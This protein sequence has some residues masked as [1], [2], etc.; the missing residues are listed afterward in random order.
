MYSDARLKTTLATEVAES[1]LERAAAGQRLDRDD[2]LNLYRLPAEQVRAA[3]HE[4]RLQRVDRPL[5]TYSIYGNIDYTNVCSVGCKFCCYFRA[6][7]ADD[8]F[9]LSHEQLGEQIA[10]MREEDVNNLLLMGGINPKLDLDWYIGMLQAAKQAHPEIWIDAFSPEEIIG[11]ERVSGLEAPEILAQ[12]KQ[13]GMD[14]LPGVSAEIL[15]DEVRHAV[16]PNRIATADW[17]RIVEA[18]FDAGLAVPCVSMVFGMGETT[19]HHVDHLLSLRDLQDRVLAKHGRGVQSFEVW[20]MRLQHSRISDSA[21]TSDPAD[22]A[23]D[24][25]H[26]LAAPGDGQPAKP[27]HRLAH[28][29]LRGRR[30]GP[31]LG[32]RRA[33]GDRDDQRDHRRHQARRPRHR[34]PRQ[35]GRTAQRHPQLHPRRRLHS[36]PSWSA[37]GD[38]RDRGRAAAV[39][40]R[41]R[42]SRVNLRDESPLAAPAS[43]ARGAAGERL[44]AADGLALYAEP[45]LIG[46]GMRARRRK[47][48]LTGEDVFTNVNCHINLTNVC[49]ASC[50]YCGFATKEGRPDAYLLSE[51][52]VAERARRAASAGVREFHLVGGLHPTLPLER[53]LG[54]FRL[55]HEEVPGANVRAF[56]AVEVDHYARRDGRSI[57]AVLEDLIEAGV[58]AITGG[59]AEIFAPAVRRPLTGHDVTWERWAAVHRAAHGMGMRTSA[60]MLY[61]HVESAEDRVDH[62][63]RL[64]ELQDDTG[65]FDVFVPLRFQP[66]GR[67]AHLTAPTATEVLR[68]FAV[69]RL[70]LDNFEHVKTFTPMNGLALSQLAIEFG[71][72]DIEGTISDYQITSDPDA[73]ELAGACAGTA[74]A[75]EPD[76]MPLAERYHEAFAA[77]ARECGWRPVARES[78]Y[79]ESA[80]ERLTA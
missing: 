44:S 52:Q 6:P 41:A 17:F 55:L 26:H 69:S 68:V 57:E 31:A 4:V 38:P 42:R 22:I 70:L 28:D 71:A 36:G 30:P 50:R 9:T 27:P 29:G 60:T 3:A 33:L 73:A 64:R 40:V 53:F 75:G 79:R 61:G 1:L 12:L 23:H 18:A 7:R 46:L 39:R 43:A 2:L 24:Y 54:V 78:G 10:C 32:C 13:A 48:E 15:V 14:A 19:E 16:A 63:L 11:M 21:P 51:Q 34:R 77:A 5:V 37:V 25:L 62:V 47:R 49:A 74:S 72:D 67:L 65:G 76:D 56:T 58:S 59:G 35:E 80:E 8:A 66:A 20:P 45:D